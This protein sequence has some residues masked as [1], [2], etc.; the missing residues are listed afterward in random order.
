[1][2]VD[3]CVCAFFC[4]CEIFAVVTTGWFCKYLLLSSVLTTVNYFK[5]EAIL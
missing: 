2:D 1:M 5:W 3:R 4:L